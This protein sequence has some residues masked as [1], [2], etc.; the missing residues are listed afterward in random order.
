ML[1]AKDLEPKDEP[2]DIKYVQ[3]YLNL[4]ECKVTISDM[5]MKSFLAIISQELLRASAPADPANGS[6]CESFCSNVYPY[7]P[8]RK[9]VVTIDMIQLVNTTPVTQ[10]FESLS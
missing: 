5:I 1:S 6:S 2:K 7:L 3:W 10:T 4:R 8:F 9:I